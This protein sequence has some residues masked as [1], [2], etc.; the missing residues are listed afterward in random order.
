MPLHFLRRRR[1][2]LRTQSFPTTAF[3]AIVLSLGSGLAYDLLAQATASVRIQLHSDRPTYPPA[4]LVNLDNPQQASTIHHLVTASIDPSRNRLT[5][6]DRVTVLHRPGA[7]STLTFSFL[8]W[9]DLALTDI[10]ATDSRSDSIGV[11]VTERERLHVRSFW[12]R[13]PY[14]E[15][16]G[17][18]HARQ[19]DLE[20][21]GAPVWPETLTV[22]VSYEGTVMDSLH[23]PRAAYARSFETTAG[24]IVEEGAFLAGSTF[25]VPSRPEDVFTFDL[26]AEVPASWRSVSQGRMATA[27][28]HGD[29]QF[30]R[31]LCPHPM[32]EIYLVAGPWE[33]HH[34]RHGDVFAQTFTYAGTDSSIYNRYLRGTGRYLDLYEE[35]IGPYPFAKFALVEN[36]WQTGFGMP[37]FT[38][39]GDRV[40]RLPFIL[41]TSY[42]HEILHNWWGNGVFVKAEEGNWCEGLTTYG[43]DY[44]YEEQKGPAAGRDYRRNALQN[45][46]DY[47]SE[48]EDLPLSRFRERHDFSTQAVGYSKSMM[49]FHQVRRALGDSTFQA[50]LQQFYRDFLWRRA[51]WSDLF[52]SFAAQ[53]PAASQRAIWARR[54]REQWIERAGAPTLRLEG[55]VR[56][57]VGPKWSVE[58]RI[59]QEVGP[60]E[61]PFWLQVPVRVVG[62][63]GETVDQV[64]DMEGPDRELSVSCSFEPV[65][66]E[67]DPDFDVLRRL[68]R[69]ETPP[70]LSQVLG[71]DSVVIVIAE[72]LGEE[73]TAA[74]RALGET[75]AKDQAAA[76]VMESAWAGVSPS[77]S[78]SIDPPP[79][80]WF[81][82]LGPAAQRE[83]TRQKAMS[84]E[85][86]SSESSDRFFNSGSFVRAGSFERGSPWGMLMPE[87][88]E[89]IASLG[90]KIPHYGK[91]S[92]LTFQGDTIHSKKVW[93]SSASPLVRDLTS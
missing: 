60:G 29:A 41:D 93:K 39:L 17:Y 89:I 74:L 83:L 57:Q 68:H 34:L 16:E 73:M 78:A 22:I 53:L 45:Y 36:F 46:L 26:R 2:P 92:F 55:A 35:Q 23:P 30:T 51:S 15:L 4:E 32:E 8:L 80:V 21:R 65:R 7:P 50:G 11:V 40:I 91:Y 82:G 69:E 59:T 70:T 24:L 72:G 52:D 47:V 81:F 1:A 48:S 62:S 25:W 66:V 61:S 75:W 31:W 9:K 64:V 18:E 33:E 67:I 28:S 71:A 19:V 27:T 44:A 10:S 6:T 37:S 56:E 85:T 79:A 63:E 54:Q 77:A 84:L 3:L 38:L 90:R 14:D 76:V 87:N 49:V 13:P 58:I 86:E 5:A 43:G 42:G 12:E 20:L 88:P